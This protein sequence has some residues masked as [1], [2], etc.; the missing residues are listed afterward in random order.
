LR[1]PQEDAKAEDDYTVLLAIVI[2][3]TIAVVS[4]VALFVM[5]YRSVGFFR[6]SVSVS[7]LEFVVQGPDDWSRMVKVEGSS[8]GSG[9]QSQPSSEEAPI[10]FWQR[11]QHHSHSTL[12]TVTRRGT[13]PMQRSMVMQLDRLISDLRALVSSERIVNPPQQMT[14]EVRE[15]S[16]CGPGGAGLF[17]DCRGLHCRSLLPF[18]RT[19]GQSPA[20]THPLNHPRA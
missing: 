18:G 16:V 9:T 19:N 8:S 5:R 17:I 7:E 12:G 3:S 4:A 1:P 20:S 2:G 15:E 10:T 11:V 6:K 14:V 13:L